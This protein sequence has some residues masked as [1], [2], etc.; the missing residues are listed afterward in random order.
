[1]DRYSLQVLHFSPSVQCAPMSVSSCSSRHCSCHESQTV[2]AVHRFCIGGRLI[3]YWRCRG[4]S[5]Y[6]F[7]VLAMWL[8]QKG[9]C[10]NPHFPPCVCQV[11]VLFSCMCLGLIKYSCDSL[12]HKVHLADT[13]WYSLCKTCL[14]LEERLLQKGF[15]TVSQNMRFFH[16]SKYS[17]EL[18]FSFEPVY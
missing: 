10:Q 1:M 6:K 18:Y 7:G 12:G 16:I 4:M 2:W 13:L 9:H 15:P 17:A 3:S 14:C 11:L 8:R 5:E